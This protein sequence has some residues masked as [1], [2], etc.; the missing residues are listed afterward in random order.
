[1]TAKQPKINA[2]MHVKQGISPVFGRCNKPCDGRKVCEKCL[3]SA[4]LQLKHDVIE[5]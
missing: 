1:M 3:F 5:V 2:C 4:H